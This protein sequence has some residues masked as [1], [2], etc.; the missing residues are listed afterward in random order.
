[1]LHA[2]RSR[3]CPPSRRA[4]IAVRPPKAGALPIAILSVPNE[5]RAG[6]AA[7]SAGPRPRTG[8]GSPPSERRASWS[9]PLAHHPF[10]RAEPHYGRVGAFEGSLYEA[11]GLYRPQA[12]CI[13]FT[14]D[15]VPFCAVCRRAIEQAIDLYTR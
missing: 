4:V 5:K 11:K 10:L 13:M 6:K 15:P 3:S 14:R 1:M 8:A 9:P 12:D 7:G 2:L